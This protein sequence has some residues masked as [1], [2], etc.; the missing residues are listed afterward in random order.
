[1][2]EACH[3]PRPQ[4]N[5]GGERGGWV[6]DRCSAKWSQELRSGSGVKGATRMATEAGKE[7][8]RQP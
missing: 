4:T 2:H 7:G 5:P 6:R 8:S 3:N 1:M